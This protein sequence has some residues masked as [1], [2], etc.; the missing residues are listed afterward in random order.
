MLPGYL[1]HIHPAEL[2]LESCIMPTSIVLASRLFILPW[3]IS[4]VHYVVESSLPA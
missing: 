1:N 2:R 4:T 3:L